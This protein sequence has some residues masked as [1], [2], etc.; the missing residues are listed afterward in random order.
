MPYHR[1]M[2]KFDGR[3]YIVFYIENLDPRDMKAIE[4]TITEMKIY[5]SEE[6]N[7]ESDKYVSKGYFDLEKSKFYNNRNTMS[8]SVR[9]SNRQKPRRHKN[10]LQNRRR[11]QQQQQT[12]QMYL[13]Q[14]P[15]KQQLKHQQ[16]SHQLQ[17]QQRQ[18][19]QLYHQ[20]MLKIHLKSAQAAGLIFYSGNATR[21]CHLSIK[22][23]IVRKV[24]TKLEI[25]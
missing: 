13:Q 7:Q 12:S 25:T 17:Q 21:N 16:N 1:K 8:D 10:Q 9:M 15:K 6:T 2:L 14:N 5:G 22:V 20:Q 4:N 19:Q 23:G 18:L 11:F 3:S 24:K